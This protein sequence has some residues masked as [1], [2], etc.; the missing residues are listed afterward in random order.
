LYIQLKIAG[1]MHDEKGY[2][3]IGRHI[4]F[5]KGGAMITD[6]KKLPILICKDGRFE[7]GGGKP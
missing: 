4:T 7:I 5:A 6:V 1:A 2:Q 3:G